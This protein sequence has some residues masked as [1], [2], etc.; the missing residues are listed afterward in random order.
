M[1]NIQ[2]KIL[3]IPGAKMKG[4]KTSREKR[5]ENLGIPREVVLCF[6]NFENAV[7]FVIGSCRKFNADILVEWKTPYNNFSDQKR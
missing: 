2:P 3:E 5:F 4:K 7:P 1:R 6:G